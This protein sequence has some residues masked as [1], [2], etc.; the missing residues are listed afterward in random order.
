MR[1]D[2]Q[3][4]LARRLIAKQWCAVERAFHHKAHLAGMRGLASLDRLLDRRQHAGRKDPPHPPAVLDQM[5][6]DALEAHATSSLYQLPDAPPP[7]KLPPPPEKPPPELEPLLHPP[8]PPDQTPPYLSGIMT[9]MK[10]KMKP[11]AARRSASTTDAP[12]VHARIPEK[13]P[14]AA[15]TSN[16]P[17]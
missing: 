6:G 15:D 14:M 5:L 2:I 9:K 13:P 11:M 1:K 7:P 12:P 3:R 10:T 8:P 17:N 16:R 4:A